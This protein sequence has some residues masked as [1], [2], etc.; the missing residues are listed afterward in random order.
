VR[1]KKKLIS[2]GSN[3]P[4]AST[5]NNTS[6]M[7]ITTQECEATWSKL[8]PY[9]KKQLIH[10][11]E[12][13][14]ETKQKCEL[15]DDVWGH[16]KEYAGIYNIT[17]EWDKVMKV[18]ASKLKI[19]YRVNTSRYITN[20]SKD[21]AEKQKKLVLKYFYKKQRNEIIMTKLFDELIKPKLSKKKH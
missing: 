14:Q 6:N 12:K 7:S 11:W 8:N 21:S 20:C 19:W 15:C 13:N 3:S 9:Q 5:T 10:L 1:V 4:R 2:N 18:S 16:I 17:T